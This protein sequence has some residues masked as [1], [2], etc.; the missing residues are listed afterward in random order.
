M[1]ILPKYLILD[2]HQWNTSSKFRSAFVLFILHPSIRLM[3][4]KLQPLP[5]K[6]PKKFFEGCGDY[7]I[8]LVL[9]GTFVS[10]CCLFKIHLIVA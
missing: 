1:F 10:Q 6:V 4:N 2:I 8:I 9:R 7:L 5:C 3:T